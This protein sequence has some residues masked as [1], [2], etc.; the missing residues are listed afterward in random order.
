MRRVNVRSLVRLGLRVGGILFV[1]I[2]VLSIGSTAMMLETRGAVV[3]VEKRSYPAKEGGGHDEWYPTVVFHTE[4]GMVHTITPTVREQYGLREPVQVG[5][6]ITVYYDQDHPEMAYYKPPLEIYVVLA[7]LVFF[8]VVMI[9]L[10]RP[11]QTAE[12]K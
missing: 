1:L 10:T 6:T 12:K 11:P 3:T 7:L 4:N 2:G 5:A 8:G 9:A